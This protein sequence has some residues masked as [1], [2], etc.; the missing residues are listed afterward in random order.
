[1]RTDGG[2]HI[3][4]HLVFSLAVLAVTLVAYA[5]L[6]AG[7][8]S[9]ADGSQQN[10]IHSDDRVAGAITFTPVFTAYVP[11]VRISTIFTVHFPIIAMSAGTSLVNQGLQGGWAIDDSGHLNFPHGLQN[12]LP[13]IA[14]AGA[15]WVRINFRLGSCYSNWTA[16]GCNGATALEQYDVLVD[17]ARSRGLRVLGLL[18]NESWQ[19]KQPEWTANSAEI[20]GGNGDNS[21][22]STF[23][24][25]VAVVLAKHFQGRIDTW[26]VWNEPNAWTANPD[27]GIYEGGTFL[28][29]SNFAW[30]LSHVYEDTRLVGIPGVWFISGGIF[31]HDIGGA[32]RMIE[33]IPV[34]LRGDYQA[35][36]QGAAGPLAALPV[37]TAS[38]GAAYL[39]NTYQQGQLNAQ[40]NRVRTMWGSYP[41][42]AV[43]QHLYLDQGGETSSAKIRSYLDDLRNVYVA[44]EGSATARKIVMTEIGWSTAFVSEAVQAKNLQT[45]YSTFKATS[46]LAN[47]YWFAIQDVPEANLYYGLQTGG[48][49]VDGHKGTPKPAFEVNQLYTGF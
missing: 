14:S 47:A 13:L 1:M 15:G 34:L 12:Q 33:G 44:F 21:Y 17:D 38:S 32:S 2:D 40:W 23:S 42:D 5:A 48:S 9:R 41:L 36:D 16:P 43:G 18:S 28:Y 30:L 31:G 24:Q 46:F 19:G 3:A 35:S 45:A 10:A 25:Q 27:S 20:S 39:A 26:E 8:P 37:S 22:L 29:P 4:R 49:D 6:C 7:P 11:I